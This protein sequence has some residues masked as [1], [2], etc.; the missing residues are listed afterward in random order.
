M[1]ELFLEALKVYGLPTAFLIAVCVG[2]WKMLKGK[3]VVIA[4]KD[5]ALLSQ[6]KSHRLEL[7]G[8]DAEI[9]RLND[10]RLEDSQKHGERMLTASTQSTELVAETNQTLELLSTQIRAWREELKR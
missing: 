6:E 9:K 2:A 4:A 10:L 5:Q 3:D 7:V 8:K 1:V